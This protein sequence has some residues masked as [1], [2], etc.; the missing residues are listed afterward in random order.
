[1][2]AGAA[3]QVFPPFPAGHPV[4][5]PPGAFVRRDLFNDPAADQQLEIPVEAGPV[6][7]NV[8]HL[9]QR[10]DV[11]RGEVA[12]V[13]R[14]DVQNRPPDGGEPHVHPVQVSV[15]QRVFVFHDAIIPRPSTP[16]KRRR[17]TAPRCRRC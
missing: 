1:M 7:C 9:H 15:E 8:L 12:F 3:K 4:E 17:S 10:Q 16:A 2:A 14:D 11:P 13:S 6:D 5:A